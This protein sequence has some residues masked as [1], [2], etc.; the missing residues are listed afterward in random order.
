M[1]RR[2]VIYSELEISKIIDKLVDE[3]K[4]RTLHENQVY[5]CILNGAYMFFSDLTKKTHCDIEIDFIRVKSIYKNNKDSIEIIK[6]IELNI[7]GKE[8]FLIDEL[9]DSGNTFKFLED[10]LTK[11]KPLKINFVSLFKKRNIN[12]PNLICVCD[13]DENIQSIWGYGFDRENGKG[14]NLPYISGNLL[15]ID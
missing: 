8:V 13:I 4:I 6:D 5:I 11:Y 2:T 1:N 14:R 3:I 12:I 15:E 9:C 10:Y 7:E